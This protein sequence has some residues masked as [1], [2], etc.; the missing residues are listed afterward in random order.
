MG[1][2]SKEIDTVINL[3]LFVSVTVKEMVKM[4]QKYG[5][6]YFILQFWGSVVY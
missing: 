2:I 1:K 4:N 6:I 5:K 3:F